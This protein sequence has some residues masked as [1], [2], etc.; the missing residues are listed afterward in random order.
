MYNNRHRNLFNEGGN[1]DNNIIENL[2]RTVCQRRKIDMARET[3]AYNILAAIDEERDEAHIHS[4]IIYFLLDRTYNGDGTDDFLH[5]F[6]REIKIPEK[7]INYHWRVCREQVFEEG[8]ID[9]VIESEKFCIAIEMK[10]DAEDGERQLERYDMFCKGKG[11]EYR[12]YYLTLSGYAPDK[13]SVGN[14]DRRKLYLISFQHEILNWLQM[15]MDTVDKGCYRYSFLKQYDAAVRHIAELDNEVMNMKD[16]LGST[17]M[18]KAALLIMDSFNKKMAEITETLFKNVGNILKEKSQLETY[19]YSNCV[20]VFIDRVKYKKKTYGLVF[21]LAIDSYLYACFGFA[22][23]SED[24]RFIP[25]ADVEKMFPEFYNTWME[26]IRALNLPKLK[27]STYTE[28]YYIE[29]TRGDKLN[30]KEN[31]DSVLELID[32]MDI[33]SQYIGMM[34]FKKALKPLLQ[35]ELH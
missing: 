16:L 25:L 34:I 17:D 10:I 27:Q 21:E 18:A 7:Y 29:N 28:W 9:F 20:D 33:Q 23:Q 12:I 14:M 26:R 2:L 35:Y 5:L 24:D 15:C 22:G 32:E 6:L 13:Q 3:S 8:R 19:V 30:F 4:K 1:M 31:S 11:K